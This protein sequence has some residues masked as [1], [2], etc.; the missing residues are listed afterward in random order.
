MINKLPKVTNKKADLRDN[1]LGIIIAV[2]GILL[3]MAA[4]YQIYHSI[5]A[6]TETT[7]AKSLADILETRINAIENN[8]KMETTIQGISKKNP[9]YLT[10]WDKTIMNR[11]D[12]CFSEPC[13]CICPEFSHMSCQENGI[14]RKFEDINEIKLPEK[15]ELRCVK[16]DNIGI[17]PP[18]CTEI[19]VSYIALPAQLMKLKIEKTTEEEKTTLTITLPKNE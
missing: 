7:K 6:N 12:K 1:T 2:I 3:L 19:M 10:G 11:P 8:G 17:A 14:C 4:S 15:S 9:W 16:T 18:I 5:T 13:I